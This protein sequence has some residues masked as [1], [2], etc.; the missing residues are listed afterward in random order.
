MAAIA[1][2]TRCIRR[3][4][5]IDPSGRI[6]PRENPEAWCGRRFDAPCSS[7]IKDKDGRATGR[8]TDPEG[9]RKDV[10]CPR[11]HGRAIEPVGDEEPIGVDQALRVKGSACRSCLNKL[12]E[13][14][15]DA[16]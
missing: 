16:A 8:A 2:S 5:V 1:I 11:C 13:A 6:G 7:C 14:L 9:I 15:L 4:M 3:L 10:K 12:A